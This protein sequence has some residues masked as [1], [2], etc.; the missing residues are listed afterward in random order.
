MRWTTGLSRKP[1]IAQALAEAAQ[2]LDVA[3]PTEVDV[4][5]VFFSSHHADQADALAIEMVRKF[6]DAVCLGVR[7]AGVVGAGEEAEGEPSLSVTAAS[8]PGVELTPLR[9][10]GD[11]HDR[12]DFDW[13]SHPKLATIEQPHFLI[14]SDPPTFETEHLLE[15]LDARFPSSEKFGGLFAGV[16][17]DNQ[18]I[19]EG[20]VYSGGAV[21][22]AFSGH[23]EVETMVAQACRPIGEPLIVTR[24]TQNI[25]HQ[26]DRGNPME[27]FRNTV[28]RLDED[29]RDLAQHSMFVGIGVDNAR[30]E[31]GQ[32]DFLIR[33]IVG[34]NPKN[35]DL[36]VAAPI[37]DLQVIQFHLLDAA[38]SSSE[39][40]R[41]L[42][43]YL[44]RYTDNGGLSGA[45]LFSCVERG[46]QLYGR[47]NHESELVA[48]RFERLPVGGCFCHG[49]IAH[50]GSKTA[51][52]GYAAAVTVFRE[53]TK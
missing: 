35:G 39:F 25:I 4:A 3:S 13:G 16:D 15:S 53:P 8:L 5:L 11:V 28:G 34:F 33:N 46:S 50:A 7:A 1:E 10:E 27:V 14:L 36:A 43:D 49:E 9:F 38:T 6:P 52:H 24:H 23:L 21:G 40:E 51:V 44:D 41:V 2:M 12:P 37:E 29:D 20:H 30:G 17:A 26:F 18:M 42:D 48:E 22:L 19:V 31:Y 32:G 47:P 45:L